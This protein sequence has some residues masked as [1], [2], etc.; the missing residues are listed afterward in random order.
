LYAIA[1]C[2]ARLVAPIA[3]WT[4]DGE[5]GEVREVRQLA[6]DDPRRLHR[7]AAGHRPDPGRGA[8]HPRET[9][10]SHSD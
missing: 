10:V 9:L 8:R 5:F 4:A 3:R 7:V 1:Q 6:G 2:G